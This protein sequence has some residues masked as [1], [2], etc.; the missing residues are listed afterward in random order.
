MYVENDFLLTD[1][2]IAFAKVGKFSHQHG[3]Y[4]EKCV[5]GNNQQ[6]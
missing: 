3:V 2:C 4:P 1:C 6:L 5:Q